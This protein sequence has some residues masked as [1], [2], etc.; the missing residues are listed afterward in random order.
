MIYYKLVKI[1]INILSLTKVIIDVI[2]R[3]YGLLDSIINNTGLLFISNF[4][5]LLYYFLDIKK[6]LFI[7]FYI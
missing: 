5:L 4:W 6:K 2:I 1:I 3:Y 7:I